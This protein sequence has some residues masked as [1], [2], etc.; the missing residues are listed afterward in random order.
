MSLAVARL[1]TERKNWRREHPKDFVA[2]PAAG[3]LMVWSCKIPGPEN[4]EWQGRLYSVTLKFS[5]EYP[6]SPPMAYFSPVLFHPNIFTNG[7]VCLSILD[8]HKDWAPSITMAQILLGLQDLLKTPNTLSPANV[9]ASKLFQSH[10][11]EYAKRIRA[12]PGEEFDA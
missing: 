6:S 10:P 11:S 5:A 3:D 1:E 8:S 7:Q 12:Q 9:E 2:K 4:T